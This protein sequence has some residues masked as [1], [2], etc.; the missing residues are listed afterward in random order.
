[1]KETTLRLSLAIAFAALS[2]PTL[3]VA[4]DFSAPTGNVMLTVSGDIAQTNVGDTLQFDYAMLTD[5]DD[6]QIETSTIWTDGV[7]VF[8]GV[9][10]HL[11]AEVLGTSSGSLRATAINDYS[12]Q[13]PVTDAIEGG[14]ILAY[15]M[16]GEKMS[17]RE[18]GPLWIIY[19]YDSAS[20]YRSEVIYSRSIWQLDRIDVVK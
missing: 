1:M 3:S 11:L 10:L 19:P 17:V 15:L 20:E 14:P 18:K 12:V 7:R 8:Q 2:W 13:I 9:S 4:Q 6:T 5:L 16:D